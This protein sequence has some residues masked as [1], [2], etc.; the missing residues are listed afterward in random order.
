[1]SCGRLTAEEIPRCPHCNGVLTMMMP[2]PEME[3]GG[4]VAVCMSNDCP[5]YSRS[6]AHTSRQMGINVGYRHAY[7]CA[8]QKEMPISS[9][10]LVPDVFI[11]IVSNSWITEQGGDDEAQLRGIKVAVKQWNA[12][13]EWFESRV[14]ELFD[15]PPMWVGKEIKIQ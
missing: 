7:V 4:P 6:F 2:L 12:S 10:V 15:K 11:P 14:D 3:Y 13:V 8:E 1:M 5:Y 9:R